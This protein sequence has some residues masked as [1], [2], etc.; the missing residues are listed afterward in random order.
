MKGNPL[1]ELLDIARRR[2]L[3]PSEQARLAVLRQQTPESP[4]DWAAEQQLTRLLRGL[5]SAPVPFDFTGRVLSALDREAVAAGRLERFRAWIAGLHLAPRYAAALFALLLLPLGY[6]QHQGATRSRV[7]ASIARITAPVSTAAQAAQLSPL[8]M[9]E[10]Y[11]AIER[12]PVGQTL[13]DDEL[14]A[15]LGS[16]ADGRIE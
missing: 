5:P 1:Q 13:A 6:L 14:L 9:L 12:M 2:P 15:A 3:S 11:Q 16:P 7:A 4:T 10:D 8:E